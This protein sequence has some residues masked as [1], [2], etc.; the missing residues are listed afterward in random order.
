MFT[1]YD[2]AEIG[3]CFAAFLSMLF[4][5]VRRPGHL[6]A[7]FFT[8]AALSSGLMWTAF[9]LFVPRDLN[10]THL[11]HG[12]LTSLLSIATG[13]WLL[14]LLVFAREPAANLFRRR[15]LTVY[16]AFSLLILASIGAFFN[17]YFILEQDQS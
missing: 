3:A 14:F 6:S 10:L 12:I 11:Q 16:A 9:I 4:V 5:L 13:M 7:H 8:A 1:L 17:N 2:L 15:S